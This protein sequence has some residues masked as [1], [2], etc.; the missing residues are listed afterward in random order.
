MKRYLLP[1]LAFFLVMF[2]LRGQMARLYTSEYGLPNTQV[3]DIYQDSRGFVWI[4]TENGLAR[5]DG[6]DFTTFRFDRDRADA[7]ASN[8]V[9]TVR[10]DS[11]GIL[12]VGTSMGLQT[13]DPDNNSFHHIDLHDP[14]SPGSTQYVSSIVEV[15]T[16]EGKSELWVATSQHGVYI[17]D[18]DTHALKDERRDHLNRNLPSP[19][20]GRIF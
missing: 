16:G 1:I 19:F 7:L 20:V 18:I 11:R 4:C 8:L 12:W 15:K 9:L 3:N 14:E 13:F 10:E 5:F 17:L 6:M 2:P